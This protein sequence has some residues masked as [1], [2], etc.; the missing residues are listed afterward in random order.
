ML[1]RALTAFVLCF[2]TGCVYA[3]LDLGLG[4]VGKPFEAR[5][6]SGSDDEK[7]VLLR[8]DGEI[9]GREEG[10]F[11]SSTPATTS[12]V[13]Q[14]LDLARA[15]DDVKAVV[16]RINSPGGGVTAS[17]VIFHELQR[18]RSETQKPVVAWFGD[19]AASGGYYVA[20][21][22]D[23][24]VAAPTCITGSIGVVST[25]YD[26]TGLEEKLGVHV[27]AITSGEY[28]DMGSM[29]RDMR[30]DERELLQALIDAMYARFVTVVDEGRPN[31]DR[32]AVERLA[33]GRIYTGEQALEA[34]LVDE[35]GYL[36]DAVDEV[37]KLAGLREP[38]LIAYERRGL[39]AEASTI[40][41][42][43]Q[44]RALGE[45]GLE[46]DLGRLAERVLPARSGPALHYLWLPGR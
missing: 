46:S 29:F 31:L 42:A 36:E 11:L 6:T 13:R 41:S 28:K 35:L 26:V 43:P 24:I 10:G 3:P 38:L 25:F 18:F 21:A 9:S 34:G 23:R 12:Q 5:L 27:H 19:T 2:S 39:S 45:L 15:D 17:D 1:G 44:L 33:D 40:Y 32:A 8:I 4:E 22:A 14:V 20:M 37:A 30:P 7:V 16:V